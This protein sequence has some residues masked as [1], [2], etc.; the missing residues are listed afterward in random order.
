MKISSA[1][2]NYLQRLLL[3]HLRG[4][5][6]GTQLGQL[7]GTKTPQM[8]ILFEVTTSICLAHCLK[9]VEIGKKNE[10]THLQLGC[11]SWDFWRN[12]EKH[13]FGC[14]NNQQ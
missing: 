5:P 7:S 8:E 12:P 9:F 11:S 4:N 3:S 10:L 1:A 14:A 13:P 2:V 6:I